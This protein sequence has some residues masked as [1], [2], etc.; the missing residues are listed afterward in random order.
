MRFRRTLII[1][2]SMTLLSTGMVLG[3]GAG[4]N[5]TGVGAPGTINSDLGGAKPSVSG[6]AQTPMAPAE[7]RGVAEQ[8]PGST[9]G[10]ARPAEDGIS[11]KMV[12][13]KPC[14][15]AAKETD[16]TTT[17]VGIPVGK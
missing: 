9:T 5:R 17:C 14:G 1:A 8:A 13:A 6:L 10:L 15:K 3:Q 2:A 7:V 4:D 11:T 12:P 16:G